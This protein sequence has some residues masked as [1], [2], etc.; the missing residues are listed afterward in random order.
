[1]T[2]KWALV[3]SGKPI[4]VAY[5]LDINEWNGE[6]KLQLKVYDIRESGTI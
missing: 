6:R 1:M 3:Q 2:D 5:S 4:D